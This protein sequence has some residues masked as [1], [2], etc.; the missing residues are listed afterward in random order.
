MRNDLYGTSQII[1]AALF[2]DNGQIDLACRHIGALRQIDI[3]KTLIMAQIK[4]SLRAVVGNENLAV[5]IR[6]HRARVHIDIRIKFLDRDP[7][8]AAFQ[9]TSQRS[10]RDPFP[11]RRNYTACY[12]NIFRHD[13]PPVPHKMAFISKN[14][15]LSGA[16]TPKMPK[17]CLIVWRAAFTSLIRACCTSGSTPRMRHWL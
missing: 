2:I 4:V 6:A 5:L 3:N 11:Q 17:A 14:Y 1:A 10:R 12:K 16:D 7:I 8:A 9:Q 15:I 13:C